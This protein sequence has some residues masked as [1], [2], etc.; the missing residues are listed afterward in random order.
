M[1]GGRGKTVFCPAR[2]RISIER[3]ADVI[4][5]AEEK[6]LV[7]EQKDECSEREQRDENECPQTGCASH[8][9]PPT[10]LYEFRD[11]WIV[12]LA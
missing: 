8:L 3:S 11:K 1:S 4:C 7:A 9:S 2:L 6:L 12:V 5:A 10:L